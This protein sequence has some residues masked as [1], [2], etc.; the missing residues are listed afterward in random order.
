LPTDELLT[1]IQVLV[2]LSCKVEISFERRIFKPAFAKAK[3]ESE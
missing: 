2:S 3:K 1:Y